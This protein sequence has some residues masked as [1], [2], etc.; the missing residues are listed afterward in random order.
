MLNRK[1]AEYLRLSVCPQVA[2]YLALS[3]GDNFL[4]YYLVR[5]STLVNGRLLDQLVFRLQFEDRI[6]MGKWRVPY[7]LYGIIVSACTLSVRYV[8]WCK[9]ILKI[10]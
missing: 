4:L 1:G 6:L 10:K 9:K 2:S 5:G 3:Q 8:P 7:L